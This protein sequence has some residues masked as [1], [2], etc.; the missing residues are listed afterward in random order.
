[1]S[2][3]SLSIGDTLNKY[4]IKRG[5]HEGNFELTELK[6]AYNF[7]IKDKNM[8][9]IEHATEDEAKD[10]Y[11]IQARI[12]GLLEERESIVNSR[13]TNNSDPEKEENVEQ[14]LNSVRKELV[15]LE[16]R[17]LGNEKT[18]DKPFLERFKAKLVD[19]NSK[20]AVAENKYKPHDLQIK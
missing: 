17:I 15:N 14:R 6:R 4:E 10:V 13:N 9:V 1:M 16:D 12:R 7:L 19:L 8:A 3:N 11:K 5:D 2:E 18:G 20:I